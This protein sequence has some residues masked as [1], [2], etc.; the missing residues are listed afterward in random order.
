METATV[1]SAKTKDTESHP[2]RLESGNLD[3]LIATYGKLL[4]EDRKREIAVN[5]VSNQKLAQE[6]TNVEFTKVKKART[7]KTGLDEQVFDKKIQQQDRTIEDQLYG[8]NTAKIF[9]DHYR[10]TI[11][12]KMFITPDYVKRD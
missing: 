11:H 2:S 8:I 4:S 10:Y 6:R 7:L 3:K 5:Q 12:P 1:T 9:Q